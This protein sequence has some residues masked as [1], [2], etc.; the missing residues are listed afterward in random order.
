MLCVAQHLRPQD[1]GVQ[2][3]SQ[4]AVAGGRFFTW[5]GSY[6]RPESQGEQEQ[7][8]AVH[9]HWTASLLFRWPYT[10][11]HVSSPGH[12]PFQAAG[13]FQG[14]HLR[15]AVPLPSSIYNTATLGRGSRMACRQPTN[16]PRQGCWPGGPC[17][18]VHTGPERTPWPLSTTATCA[19]PSRLGFV[20]P[21]V[22]MKM[23][24]TD[25]L[26]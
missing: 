21:R 10:S 3:S 19:G 8:H 11:L 14:E 18:S 1:S 26:F 6:L 24:K 12:Q 7:C 2:M 17:E 5:P 9:P 4:A 23:D 16:G 20:S 25:F 15:F 13:T 22:H